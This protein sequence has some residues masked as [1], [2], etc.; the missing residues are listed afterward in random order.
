MKA[1]GMDGIEL[2]AYGHLIDQFISPLTNELDFPL[3]AA[4]WTTACGSVSMS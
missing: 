4:R 2:E 3:M 1:G